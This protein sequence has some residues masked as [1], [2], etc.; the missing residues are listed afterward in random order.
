M[1]AAV[2]LLFFSGDENPAANDSARIKFQQ[3]DSLTPY[4]VK[5]YELIDDNPFYFSNKAD[6]LLNTL[7]R[8]PA[9]IDEQTNYLDFI[10]NIAYHLL[11]QGQIPA[12]CRW[13]ERGLNYQQANKL[14][15]ETAEYIYKPLG[16]NYVRLGDYDKAVAM[17][18][19]AIEEAVKN[20]KPE[21]LPSLYSNLAISYYWLKKYDAVQKNCNKGLDAVDS[22]ITVKGLLYNVKADAFY[23]AGMKDS[24][25]YYN[26][27]ALQFFQS[28][29]AVESD[30]GWAASA[31]QLSAKLLNDQQKYQAAITKLRNAEKILEEQYPESRQRDKAK[32][33]VEKGN[34][35]LKINQYDSSRVAFVKGISYFKVSRN[36]FY[37][38]HTVTALYFGLAQSFEQMDADNSMHYYQL[39]VA[40]DYYANQLIT[41]SYNSLAGGAADQQMQ[42][43]SIAAF[44]KQFK[45]T[46]NEQHIRQMLWLIELNKGR[47]LLNEVQ[48]SNQW[49]GD[50]SNNSTQQM[51]RELR[52]D[53]LLLAETKDSAVKQSIQQRIRAQELHLGLQEQRFAALLKEPSFEVF[54]Q[55]ISQLV[56]Q[57]T[58]VSYY[59][60]A[61]SLLKIVCDSNRIRYD[62]MP[63]AAAENSVKEFVE[64]YFT[65]NSSAY[66]NNPSA[67][68]TTANQLYKFLFPVD[69]NQTNRLIIS[70]D[71]FIHLLPFEA[72]VTK[73]QQ[74][75]AEEKEISYTYSL[76]QYVNSEKEKKQVLPVQIFTFTRDHLNFPALPNASTEAALIKKHFSATAED[77]VQTAADEFLQNIQ[78]PSVLHVATHAVADDSLQQPYLVLK[79]KLYLGQLQY[80]TTASPLVVLTA[81]ETA[82]G[83]L[84]TG[85]G[86]VSLARAFISKGVKGVVASRWKVDDAVAPVFVKEFYLQLKE[87][88]SPSAALFEA[89]KKYLSTAANLSAK[90]PMLWAGF[91]YTGVEQEVDLKTKGGLN[92]LWL[93]LF[94]IFPF[95]FFR[96][97]II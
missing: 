43:K 45:L 36:G 96:K 2:G 3:K 19:L 84:Q 23:E 64:T 42:Q 29:D 65:V 63:R 10:L 87:N 12:S 88:H 89:R 78:Q 59:A 62:Q 69:I 7:W 85:E 6:S 40:N 26:Q 31:L 35:F 13:Y 72:L 24:A 58:V 18:E 97:K 15:Y 9:T 47:K 55:T 1:C 5:L 41:S 77:A 83:T 37:P 28:P 61:D 33:Q 82:A 50:S 44:E 48:R 60:G 56:K 51:F 74:F 54:Q 14:V 92:W 76:L 75:V 66:S 94:L 67:Y 53:Y 8:Q 93:L 21:L 32:L 86:V 90:N 22:N 38:D 71:A 79:N 20:N 17:Q 30:H 46:G 68:F 95:I 4:I 57:A 52:Y 91:C 39:A 16:N 11:Q 27:K 81:C 80:T 73:E 49:K 70:P 34:L 25:A